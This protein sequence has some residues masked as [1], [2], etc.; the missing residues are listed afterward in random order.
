MADDLSA[1]AKLVQS[2]AL[3]RAMLQADRESSTN[4]SGMPG[5]A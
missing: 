5:V 4:R 2:G 1:A 3:V